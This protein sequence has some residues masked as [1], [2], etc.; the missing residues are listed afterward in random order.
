MA[1][2]APRD[3]NRN[4][5]IQGT[6]N[7]DGTSP[8]NLWANPST[9]ALLVSASV[10]LSGTSDVNLLSVSGSALTLGQA[11]ATASLPIV[12]TAAQITTLTPPAAIIG[13]AT[14]TTLA[15]LNAKLVSGTDI[16]D[17][18]VNNGAGAGAVNIQDGGNVITVDGTIAFS[19]TTIA[20]TQSTSPWVVSAI[21]LDIRDLTATD[22]VTVTNAVGT[23]L[24][25]RP[26][27]G[28]NLDTSAISGSVT[29]NAGT[30]LNTST[31]LTS[32]DFA[33]AFGTAGT[34]DSQVL[35]IQGITSMTPV[36]VSQAT[37]TNLHM[38]LDSGT[39]TTITNT[40]PTKEIIASTAAG[41]SVSDTNVSTTLLAAN[42]N[43]LGA[44]IYNDSTAILYVKFGTTASAT[45]FTVQMNT[46]DYYEIPFRYTGRLDGI[47]DSD[48]SGA[49]K[50]T[51]LTA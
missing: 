13:F 12:L 16:G 25:I 50:I 22:I 28:V 48:A 21:D 10:T 40:V 36:Q 9:H 39:V 33:A 1:D 35:S 44:T 49:A 4:V 6:S 18:T 24:Y 19:N 51:E 38:V 41:T 42:A 26:G 32:S 37:G 15:A 23:G 11:L 3:Q 45:D 30:N 27:T 47:W 31:L 43:R 46:E 14:E 34:A 8:V 17:V 20:V 5:T 2:T 7:A 29:A